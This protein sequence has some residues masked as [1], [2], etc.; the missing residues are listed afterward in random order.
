MNVLFMARLYWPHI[1]GVEKHVYEIGQKLKLKG[2]N[3]T[4]VAERHDPRLLEFEVH[5]GVKIWRIPLPEGVGESTKKWFIWK[6][7]LGHLDL[8]TRAEIIHI[9]DV[10]FWFWPFRLPYWFKKVYITFHGYEGG[11]PSWKQI[12]WHRLAAFLT[13]GNICIGDFHRKWYGVIPTF[14]SYGAVA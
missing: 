11:V 2:H 1:G 10:F 4:I 7:W 6:W 9:H 13:S 14:V 12:F 8:F 5:E 3:L